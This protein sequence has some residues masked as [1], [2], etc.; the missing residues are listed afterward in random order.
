VTPLIFYQSHKFFYE[1]LLIF[2]DIF[3]SLQVLEGFVGYVVC[4]PS[5]LS[6]LRT[7]LTFSRLLFSLFFNFSNFIILALFAQ[8]CFSPQSL[9]YQ[10]W[11]RRGGG[12]RVPLHLPR[13][14][15][16]QLYLQVSPQ[17]MCVTSHGPDSEEECVFPFT[18]QGVAYSNCIYRYRYRNLLSGLRIRSQLST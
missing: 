3:F 14:R 16:Q 9:F 11:T 1:L 15:L 17:S 10:P 5:L 12:V 6:H 2:S 4:Y 7:F 13:G 18:Y 8:A